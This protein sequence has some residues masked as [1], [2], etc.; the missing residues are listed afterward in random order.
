V[1]AAAVF[2][3]VGLAPSL[4]L[5]LGAGATLY[6]MRRRSRAVTS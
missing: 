6:V 1:V 4:I 5:G 2:A 3:R